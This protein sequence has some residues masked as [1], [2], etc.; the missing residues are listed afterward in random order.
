MTMN[1]AY[2]LLGSNEGDRLQ[3]LSKG[4]DLIRNSSTV[5]E[6]SAIY[7]TAAWGIEDQ[8]DFLNIAIAIST[9]LAPLE[10]LQEVL[11]IEQTLGRQ[12][13][14]KWG[15]R[16]LD[17]DILFYN[18]DVIKEPNLSVPHPFIQYRRFALAPMNDIA[19]QLIHPILNKSI[20]QLLQD[21]EDKLEAQK[22]QLQLS[23]GLNMP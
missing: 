6:V 22:T 18:D 23:Q 1:K 21:C 10:L 20:Q 16:I 19:P 9:P 13:T 15:Q 4:V 17:I 2:L 11:S 12:R 5:T 3:W 7:S 14:I 8:P